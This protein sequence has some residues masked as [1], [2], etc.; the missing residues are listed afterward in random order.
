VEAEQMYE[1]ALAGRQETLGP[2]HTST[3]STINNLGN[4]YCYQDKL[5]EAE[6]KYDQALKGRTKAFG[7][8]P[9]INIEHGP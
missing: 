3:L 1:R 8:H 2:D 6:Q 4:I 9:H 7:P 5:A